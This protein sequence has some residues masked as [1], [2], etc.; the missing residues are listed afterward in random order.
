MG[1]PVAESN[2][3]RPDAALLPEVTANGLVLWR[4]RVPDHQLW[5]TVEDFAGELALRVHDQ[6][7][8]QTMISETHDTAASVVERADELRDR[9]MADGWDVVDVD[10]DETR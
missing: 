8:D 10:L 1:S 3:S 7:T 9:F 2:S 4:L 6:A 5:C